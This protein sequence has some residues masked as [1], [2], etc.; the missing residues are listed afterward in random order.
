MRAICEIAMV[1][2]L[3]AER[4]RLTPFQI[5]VFEYSGMYALKIDHYLTG[6]EPIEYARPVSV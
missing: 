6:T 4:Q 2:V 3:V 5:L 1:P